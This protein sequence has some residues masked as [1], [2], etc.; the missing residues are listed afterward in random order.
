MARRRPITSRLSTTKSGIT[1]EYGSLQFLSGVQWQILLERAGW[2]DVCRYR[3]YD[4][5]PFNPATFLG[6]PPEAIVLARQLYE[7][8]GA[9]V[10]T[11]NR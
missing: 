8:E 11:A 4:R 1:R 5:R 6:H 2:K 7:R 10:I 9:L 3:F